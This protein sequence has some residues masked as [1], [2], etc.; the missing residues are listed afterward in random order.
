MLEII[1]NNQPSVITLPPV[2]NKNQCIGIT[3][4]GACI[5]NSITLKPG[6]VAIAERG[7]HGGGWVIKIKN[8]NTSLSL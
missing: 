3:T 6:E 7:K 8:T 1:S 4:K 2:E 5:V